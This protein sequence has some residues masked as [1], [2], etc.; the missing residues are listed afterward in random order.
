MSTFSGDGT[1]RLGEEVQITDELGSISV[2]IPEPEAGHAHPVV[3]RIAVALSVVS[4][5]SI[6][7]LMLATT[8]DVL[9]RKLIGGGFAGVVEW[10]EVILVVTVFSGMTAA[11][12]SGAHIRGFSFLPSNR[13][14]IAAAALRSLGFLITAAILSWAAIATLQSGLQS[15]SIGEFRMGLAN[16]PV[17]PA[18][19]AIPLGLIFFAALLVYFAVLHLKFALRLYARSRSRRRV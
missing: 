11:E 9:A 8:Y 10:S 15:Y 17:W 13:E 3:R 14:N 18:K 5:M 2:H 4:G 7:L 1:D 19:L 12:L 6:V 16:V